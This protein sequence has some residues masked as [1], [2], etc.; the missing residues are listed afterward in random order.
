MECAKCKD[1]KDSKNE[2]LV[3]IWNQAKYVTMVADLMF[4]YDFISNFLNPL[5]L[6]YQEIS[7]L[8][9][10]YLRIYDQ[11]IIKLKIIKNNLS[12]GIETFDVFKTYDY[13]PMIREYAIE[14]FGKSKIEYKNCEL[15]P[16]LKKNKMPENPLYTMHKKW[17]KYISKWIAA[18]ENDKRFIKLE[19]TYIKESICPVFLME[20]AQLKISNKINDNEYNEIGQGKLLDL[21]LYLHRPWMK[22]EIIFK[23]FNIFKI[24]L[25]NIMKSG[26]L[27]KSFQN[28]KSKIDRKWRLEYEI[29]RMFDTMPDLN[30]DISEFWSLFCYVYANGMSETDCESQYSQ[31]KYTTTNRPNLETKRLSNISKIRRNGPKLGDE[32]AFLR[33]VS[34]KCSILFNAPLAKQTNLPFLEH[35]ITN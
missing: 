33:N 4:L 29:I 14:I 26:E 16:D 6:Y 9:W 7:H 2:A 23:E 20:K 34:K 17:S 35:C 8:P 32:N 3:K 22:Y 11:N 25:L 15:L 1:S 27:F 21:C 28:T 10:H 5:S 24:R 19:H 12:G 13:L 31:I 18:F 30:K